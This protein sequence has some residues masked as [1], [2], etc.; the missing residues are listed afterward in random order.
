MNEYI[1]NSKKLKSFKIMRS[2]QLDAEMLDIELFQIL[3]ENFL[4]IFPGNL[5]NGSK[6]SYDPEI[7]ALLEYLI[8]MLSIY[9]LS[10]ASYGSQLQNLKWFWIQLNRYATTNEFSE[11]PESDF[12][13][14]LWKILQ[15]IENFF[16]SLSLINYIIFLYNGR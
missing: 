10:G 1:K 4:N 3:K 16:K 2:S 15:K 8:N 5:F 9:S 14:K 6:E 11:L 7:N 13:H 12:R